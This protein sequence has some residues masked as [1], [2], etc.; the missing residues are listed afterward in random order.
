MESKFHII[1]DVKFTPNTLSLYITSL[2]TGKPDGLIGLPLVVTELSSRYLVEFE[3]VGR[4]QVVN[5]AFNKFKKPYEKITEFLYKMI[6]SQ[7]LQEYGDSAK[8][9]VRGTTSETTIEHYV[10]YSENF[11]VDVLSGTPPIIKIL[12]K[13]IE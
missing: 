7:Y 6:D 4:F 1:D 10:V 2:H 8:F 5:E 11:V 12:N 9:F 3:V 13:D